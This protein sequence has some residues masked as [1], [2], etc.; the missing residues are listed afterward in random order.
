MINILNS[1]H[2]KFASGP[3]LLCESNLVSSVLK[4]FQ[5]RTVFAGLK[6]KTNI[7]NEILD[8][9]TA[10][11]AGYSDVLNRNYNAIID[12]GILIILIDLYHYFNII[13]A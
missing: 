8:E 5:N 6:T 4:I 7:T 3:P 12:L 1:L 2:K 13:N 10:R 9:Q 11:D